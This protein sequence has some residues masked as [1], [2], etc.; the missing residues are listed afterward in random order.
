[1]VQAKTPKIQL[2]QILNVVFVLQ[3]SEVRR[4]YLLL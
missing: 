4:D 3:A 1:M 2:A